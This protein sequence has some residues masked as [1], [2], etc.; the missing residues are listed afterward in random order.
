[1]EERTWELKLRN[2]EILSGMLSLLIVGAK[3]EPDAYSISSSYITT[4]GIPYW[5]IEPTKKFR[6]WLV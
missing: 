1:M 5:D 3:E 6:Q 2:K 4:P